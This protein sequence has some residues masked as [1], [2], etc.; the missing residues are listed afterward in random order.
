[1]EFFWSF[2]G[3]W[4]ILKSE[5]TGKFV[6]LWNNKLR[7]AKDLIWDLN[8]TV[9]ATILRR[10]LSWEKLGETAGEKNEK[11]WKEKEASA[12]CHTQGSRYPGVNFSIFK[13]HA[14]DHYDQTSLT[15]C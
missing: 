3:V 7:H 5:F 15:P 12:R 2:A 6:I 9:V 10:D 14:W 13:L 11:I 1:M 4:R 8:R